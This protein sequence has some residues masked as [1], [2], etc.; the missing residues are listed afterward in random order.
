VG[1]VNPIW[2]PYAHT[3]APFAKLAKV[4]ALTA[5]FEATYPHHAYV[6]EPQSRQYLTHGTVGLPLRRKPRCGQHQVAQ[7]TEAQQHVVRHDAHV[8]AH[9]ALEL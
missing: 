3:K 7:R 2:F 5:M 1:D 8:A 6:F 9:L 4:H